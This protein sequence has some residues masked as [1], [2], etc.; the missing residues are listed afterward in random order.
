MALDA[1][2]VEAKLKGDFKPG[3]FVQFDAAMKRSDKNVTA[4]ERRVADSS[5]RTSHAVG[6]MGR[7]VGVTTVG[8]FALLTAGVASS[9]KSYGDYSKQMA[10]VQAVS[11]GTATQMK[12]LDAEQKRVGTSTKYNATQAASAS[13]ELIKAGMSIKQV[14]GG[15]LTAA[16]SLA[17]AGDL[18]LADAAAYTANAM[19]LFGIQA[20]NASTIADGFSTAANDTTAD[21][22]DFG[23]ALTQGGSAA[24][25]AGLNFTDTMVILESLAKAGI[26]NSDA[27]TSMKTA[28]L[29]LISPTKKQ[30]ALQKELGLSFVDRNGKMKDG[31]KISRDL[32][33][34]TKDKTDAERTA[35]FK[36][37]AG[38]D[39]IR[40]LNAL[41]AA[42]PK[43]LKEYEAAQKL[44]GSAQRVAAEKQEG[45]AG[46][47]AKSQAAF[48]TAK[49]IIGEEFA[50]MISK[51]ADGFGEFI[52]EAQ[53]SGDLKDF[54]E[55]LADAAQDAAEFGKELFEVG[56]AAYEAGAPLVDV[57]SG[58][59]GALDA[60]PDGSVAAALGGIAAAFVAM[61][62]ASA[63]APGIEAA[64]L[65]IQGATAASARAKG[66]LAIAD[67]LAG[68]GLM[69]RRTD[70]EFSK[71]GRRTTGMRAGFASLA[72]GAAAG[73]AALGP[74]GG[75]AL[76]AGAA[77]TIYSMSQQRAAESA[78]NAADAI[79]AGGEAAKT[80]GD[81]Y[82]QAAQD[83]ITAE[84]DKAALQ[85]LTDARDKA[86]KEGETKR[87]QE[88]NRQIKQGKLTVDASGRKADQSL[89]EAPRISAEK[90]GASLG[91]LN[92]RYKDYNEAAKEATRAR[93]S[94]YGPKIVADLERETAARRRAYEAQ[95]EEV[96][97]MRAMRQLTSLNV[98]R[99][100]AGNAPIDLK[101]ARGVQAL[102][103]S[104]KGV[105]KTVRTKLLVEG[106][107]SALGKLG[108]LMD[109]FRGI[110]SE[111]R[112]KAI[113]TGDGTV[114]QKIAAL[115][116]L[117]IRDKNFGINA[118]D[119]A[120][121]TIAQIQQQKIADKF[122]SI[123]G[124]N[125]GKKHASGTKAGSGHDALVGEEHPHE[126]VISRKTGKGFVTDGPMFMR[127]S[128]DDY[129]IPFDQKYSG[130]AAGLWESLARDL[131]IPAF[132][133]GKKPKGKKPPKLSK[134]FPIPP[135]YQKVALSQS[136]DQMQSDRDN[137]KQRYDTI[138]GKP[139]GKR[140]GLDA[141]KKKFDKLNRE[142]KQAK[143]FSDAIAKLE[144]QVEL[145][146]GDMAIGAKNKDSAL[147]GRGKE[148]R[149]KSLDKLM[150]WLGDAVKVAP[151]SPW[152][153]ELKKK[154]NDKTLSS[155]EEGP[156]FGDEN[157]GE[158]LTKAE[159]DRLDK[160]DADAALAE[161][162]TTTIDDDR[163]ALTGIQALR[164]QI[165]GRVQSAGAPSTVISDAARAAKSARDAVTG[166]TETVDSGAI[167]QQT[168]DRLAAAE[169]DRDINAKALQA[170]GGPG[171]IASGGRN[172]FEAAGG[173]TF[174][175]NN[176]HPADPAMAAQVAGSVVSG[177]NAQGNVS[178]SRARTGI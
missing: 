65:A 178:T 174:N 177:F 44:L 85:D 67:G 161:L 84:G 157:S 49:V 119:N 89:A 54:G 36:T 83:V 138:K 86:R 15:G 21:V 37:L 1:G 173:V 47:V 55:D 164:E 24:K 116:A 28:L 20:K 148:S 137:A 52:R 160:L 97:Q 11:R 29:Q 104:L 38:T 17:A 141:A 170:F 166:L 6:T 60:L 101:D 80:A 149:K 51:A 142:Y 98:Q 61:K 41:Y 23:M 76:A 64:S 115:K 132:G 128:P 103:E 82:R 31:I 39:G 163:A 32:Q 133:K 129:V 27:G 57:L 92:E 22:A 146:E 100:K 14:I 3:G 30:A 106:S 46:A 135:K 108:A 33:R 75:I 5:R 10:T 152:G 71:L 90:M 91:K 169:K 74:V 130:R 18:E 26:K 167:L 42:G 96:A 87:V 63:V 16:L 53:E 118:R 56:K 59:A 95:K 77:F 114:K 159:Q 153:R 144:D 88:L 81:E 156:S 158:Y 154:L 162:T 123:F 168:K 62:V 117:A 127:L 79:K 121:P 66:G 125:A 139:K 9:V 110:P 105:P 99:A 172:A 147:Y 69:A 12:Q 58:I 143:K 7:A 151:N 72:G 145:A 165:L 113:L 45:M 4:F 25:M 136:L 171:D 2:T 124:I 112:A 150:K 50:P 8:A 107:S 155:L 48:E 109:G 111:K 68:A 176:L 93:F 73:A 120:S 35:I 43:K 140:K 122:F 134:D 40:T 102:K 78:R 13:V 94:N 175:F 126:A 34:A 19:N 131:G 70:G